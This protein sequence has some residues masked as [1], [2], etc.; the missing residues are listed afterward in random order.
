MSR[1]GLDGTKQELL[2]RHRLALAGQ[3]RSLDYRIVSQIAILVHIHNELVVA[4]AIPFGLIEAKDK[5]GSGGGVA[6][7]SIKR[8]PGHRLGFLLELGRLG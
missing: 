1:R 5:G 6:T 3:R 4:P 2:G 7:L 8:M